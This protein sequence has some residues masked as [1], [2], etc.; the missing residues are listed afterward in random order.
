MSLSIAGELPEDSAR[1][2]WSVIAPESLQL[3]GPISALNVSED[4]TLW[5]GASGGA[6]RVINDEVTLY[7]QGS[8]LP[9]SPVTSIAVSG[10]VT[11]FAHSSGV[12]RLKD[13]VWSHYGSRVGAAG[14][15]GALLT[16]DRGAV[17]ALTPY[18]AIGF[19][20]AD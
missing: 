20:P 17:W 2:D 5:V 19:N 8:D 4:G 16:D 10:D 14:I 7:A 15:T 3:R 18:G 9:A 13:G 1:A 6:A 11:Y 12:S